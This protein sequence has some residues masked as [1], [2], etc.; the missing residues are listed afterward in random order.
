MCSQPSR[1]PSRAIWSCCRSTQRNILEHFTCLTTAFLS[2]CDLLLSFCSARASASSSWVTFLNAIHLRST[3]AP[4][5]DHGL[6]DQ[7]LSC[8]ALVAAHTFSSAG[9]RTGI[10]FHTLSSLDGDRVL[11]FVSSPICVLAS[12]LRS[13]CTVITERELPTISYYC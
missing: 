5:A 3:I 6:V 1:V 4:V 12:C 11:S 7:Q 13:A 9:S 2:S 10:F 8:K